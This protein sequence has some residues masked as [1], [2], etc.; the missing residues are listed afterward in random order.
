MAESLARVI[1][2]IRII[3]VRWWS[4]LPPSTEIRKRANTVSDSTLSNSAPNSVSFLALAE[5][6]GESSVSS[7]QP[8]I[9]VPKR[10]H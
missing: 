4:Y 5:F 8:I 10:T 6:L 2:T 3:S 1:A 9:C 7:S